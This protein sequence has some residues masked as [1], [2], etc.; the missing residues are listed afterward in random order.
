[1]EVVEEKYAS[2]SGVPAADFCARL[3]MVG[4]TTDT[5]SPTLH[6]CLLRSDQEARQSLGSKDSEGYCLT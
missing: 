2:V 5:L 6:K 1:M 3:W 4:S